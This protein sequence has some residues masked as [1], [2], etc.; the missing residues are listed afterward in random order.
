MDRLQGLFEKDGSC[1]VAILNMRSG[2]E[3]HYLRW[4]SYE[5]FLKERG[6]SGPVMDDYNIMYVRAVEALFPEWTPEQIEKDVFRFLENVYCTF[7][8]G[9][10]E[11]YKGHSLSMSDVIGLSDGDGNVHW[12]YVDSYGF[13]KLDGFIK[14]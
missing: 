10:V 6:G 5:E 13:K 11:G 1:K 7:Q 4:T 2:P 8:D 14:P 3:W 9:R 12:F